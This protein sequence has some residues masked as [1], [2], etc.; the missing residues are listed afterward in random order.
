VATI[1][2]GV[3]VGLG[4]GVGVIVGVLVIVGVGVGA[5]SS[6]SGL[7]ALESA[8]SATMSSGAKVRRGTIVVGAL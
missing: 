6:A 8:A 1:G 2:G 4:V 5:G 7:Q 3:G